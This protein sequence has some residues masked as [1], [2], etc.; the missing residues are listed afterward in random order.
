[1][2]IKLGLQKFELREH[3]MVHLSK[4]KYP[5]GNYSKL[6]AKKEGLCEVLKKVNDNA[7]IVIY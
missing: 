5:S 3:V 2:L 6:K 7:Y 4:D 1:M